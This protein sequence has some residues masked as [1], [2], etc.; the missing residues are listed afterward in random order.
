MAKKKVKK[1]TISY[2]PGKQGNGEQLIVTL[3]I[4]IA[5]KL[6]NMQNHSEATVDTLQDIL[7]GI[8]DNG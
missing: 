2:I 3:L 7:K 4:Q 8:E 6:D 5:Q 1:E